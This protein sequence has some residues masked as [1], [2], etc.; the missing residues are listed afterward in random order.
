[1]AFFV[2]PTGNN[3]FQ[4]C[5]HR[6]PSLHETLSKKHFAQLLPSPLFKGF[7]WWKISAHRWIYKLTDAALFAFRGLPKRHLLRH[8]HRMLIA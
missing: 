2:R 1:M 8:C 3:P 6:V 4:F 5:L 7:I